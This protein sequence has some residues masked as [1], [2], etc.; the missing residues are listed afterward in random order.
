[1]RA[2]APLRTALLLAGI[3]SLSATL[4][5]A[6]EIYQ[7]KDAKGVTHYSDS[8]PAGTTHTTR[9]LAA[10]PPAAIAAA[11]MPAA[12]SD[13]S[14]ARSNLALLQGQAKVGVDEDK[15]GKPDREL[16]PAERASRLKLAEA[17]MENYCDR[18]AAEAATSR[19]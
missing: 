7:W 13:C 12:N 1:M 3:L 9:A 15:D 4:A 8:P 16:T 11:P 5:T 17:Q 2:S 6:G 10:R 18:P 14:N 19:K